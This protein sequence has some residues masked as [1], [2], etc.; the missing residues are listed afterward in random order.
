MFALVVQYCHWFY[1]QLSISK[2]YFIYLLLKVEDPAAECVIT[3]QDPT[4]MFQ[5][6]LVKGS[7]K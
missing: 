4:D 5:L 2:C 6:E 7:I 3:Q 1:C